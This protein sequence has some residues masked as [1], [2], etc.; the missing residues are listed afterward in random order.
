MSD[1]DDAVSSLDID[2]VE[3]DGTCGI[4]LDTFS[5]IENCAIMETQYY[6]WQH[7][8]Y[9]CWYHYCISVSINL[10]ITIVLMLVLLEVC[11][12]VCYIDCRITISITIV[13]VLVIAAWAGAHY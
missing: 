11:I 1:M 9:D 13:L 7:A 3:E 6:Q 4:C 2:D 12:T 10:C 5:E 8:Q